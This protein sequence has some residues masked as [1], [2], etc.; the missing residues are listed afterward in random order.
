MGNAAR[1]KESSATL[2]NIHEKSVE[3][4]AVHIASTPNVR[5]KYMSGVSGVSFGRSAAKHPDRSRHPFV[6]DAAVGVA[7]NHNHN[8]HLIKSKTINIISII[9]IKKF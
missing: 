3:I 7:H 4:L 1:R 8:L 5:K 6:I 9:I 2:N